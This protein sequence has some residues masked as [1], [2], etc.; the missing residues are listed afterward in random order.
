MAEKLIIMSLSVPPD[1]Q[2]VLKNS[3]KVKQVSTSKLVRNLVEQCLPVVADVGLQATLEAVAKKKS[4]TIGELV[5]SLISKHLPSDQEFPII[6]KV[7]VQL[8][9]KEAELKKWLD[10]RVEGILKALK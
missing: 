9:G 7:P 5:M 2:N 8:K 4:I 6:L 3:A 1:M 10:Q